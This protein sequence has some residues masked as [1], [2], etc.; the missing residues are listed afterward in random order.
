MLHAGPAAARD[1]LAQLQPAQ[2][3]RY[4][5]VHCADVGRSPYTPWLLSSLGA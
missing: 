3:W 5:F 4:L 2:Q 1:W